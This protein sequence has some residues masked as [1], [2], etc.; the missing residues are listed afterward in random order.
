MR[1][2]A[3]SVLALSCLG[4]R[5]ITYPMRLLGEL[6][7][8]SVS[9]PITLTWRT[10]TDV[11]YGE[12]RNWRASLVVGNDGLGTVTLLDGGAGSFELTGNF[13]LGFTGS[14]LRE[15]S[16]PSLALAINEEDWA[17]LEDER[18]AFWYLFYGL[19]LGLFTQ[20]VCEIYQIT[21]WGYYREFDQSIR[22]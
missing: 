22:G 7:Q 14:V 8:G 5:P 16:D 15:A 9:D 2:I 6:G 12:S 4:A 1:L 20:L 17:W 13:A 3:L 10:D 19:G 11:Y 21:I 18:A